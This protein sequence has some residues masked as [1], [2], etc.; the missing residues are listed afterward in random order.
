MQNAGRLYF[1]EMIAIVTRLIEYVT[2]N[3][4]IQS[5]HSIHVLGNFDNRMSSKL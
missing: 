1:L 5:I 3:D 4:S 2:M